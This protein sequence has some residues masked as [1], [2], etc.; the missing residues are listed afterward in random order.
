[1]L[2]RVDEELWVVPCHL[3]KAKK[4]YHINLLLIHPEDTYIDIK[5]QVT[6]DIDGD[7]LGPI[8][9]HY[10]WIKDLSKLLSK[11]NS[12]PD[13]R[14]YFCKRCL[15]GYH[16]PA[17]LEAHVVDCAQVNECRVAMPRI[18]VDE[19]GNKS[20]TVKFKDYGHKTKVPFVVY[21]GIE[22]LLKKVDQEHP[23][24][25]QPR[26]QLKSMNT[27][28]ALSTCSAPS[29]QRSTDSRHTAV[30]IRE[31]DSR[32]NSKSLPKPCSF[33]TITRSICLP[34]HPKKRR[35]SRPHDFAIS[36]RSVSSPL[37]S[38]HTITAIW[39]VGDSVQI[40]V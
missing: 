16:S 21:A 27:S 13:G 38:V 5:A 40:V 39:Q 28:A 11:Q 19:H 24:R 29:T 22:S 14:I 34:Y 25:E 36:V 9:F 17:K 18:Y 4:E 32:N 12:K 37:T 30:R 20:H 35:S 31:H 8:P 15:H 7:H 23:S 33:C 3:T 26:G 1:M 10:V 6:E 2:E